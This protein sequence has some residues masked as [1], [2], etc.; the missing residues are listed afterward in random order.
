M[1]C[2]TE[3]VIILVMVGE[4]TNLLGSRRAD[5]STLVDSGSPRTNLAVA[6]TRGR[7]VREDEGPDGLHVPISGREFTEQRGRS[8]DITGR[9]LAQMQDLDDSAREAVTNFVE[10]NGV[11]DTV[12]ETM[13]PETLK[14]LNEDAL[15]IAAD[16]GD[17][18]PSAADRIKAMQNLL[19]HGDDITVAEIENYVAQLYDSIGKPLSESQL[20]AELEN[21]VTAKPQ[22]LVGQINGEFGARPAAASEAVLPR[23]TAKLTEL[24]A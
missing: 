7:R 15:K 11:L 2:N 10:D 21:F 17:D 5:P 6:E 3:H 8:R 9:E 16:K 18:T 14:L 20:Q 4:T 22:D 24:V 12:K 13:S 23:K 19:T 1:N